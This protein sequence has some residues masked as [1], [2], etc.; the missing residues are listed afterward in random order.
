MT[1]AELV[2]AYRRA[3]PESRITSIIKYIRNG[4]SVAQ[5]GCVVCGE[6]GPSWSS[7][8]TKTKKA[9]AW[10]AAHIAS[11]LKGE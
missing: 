3:H 7:K 6:E 4:A 11:H 10:E 2:A 5:R 9:I 8:W 1:E